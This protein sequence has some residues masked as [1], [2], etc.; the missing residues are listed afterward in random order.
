MPRDVVSITNDDHP[1]LASAL[2]RELVE[3]RR[4]QIEGLLS[5]K[6]WPDFEKRRGQINGLATSIAICQQVRKRIEA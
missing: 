6:D 1:A 2:E 5:S 4:K 3:E